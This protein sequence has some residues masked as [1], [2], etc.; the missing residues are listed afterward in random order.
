MTDPELFD[1]FTR[2]AVPRP[3]WTHR[4]HLRIAWIFLERLPPAAALAA[5][6]DGIK[7]LNKANGVANT[8][9]EGYHETVTRAFIALIHDARRCS[10]PAAGSEAFC[11]RHPEL[12]EKATLLRHYSRDR[13]NSRE[14]RAMFVEPDL[15][16]LPPE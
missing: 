2:A 5:V 13:I 10:A 9:D 8:P 11:D 7:A 4:A 3:L 6:R 15:S 16:P 12:F 1:A 14:A